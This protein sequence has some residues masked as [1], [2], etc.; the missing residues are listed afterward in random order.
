MC[1]LTSLNVLTIFSSDQCVVYKINRCNS[2]DEA[3]SIVAPEVAQLPKGKVHN[4]RRKSHVALVVSLYGS[5][6]AT[7]SPLPAPGLQ[8]LIMGFRCF[9][10]AGPLLH[11]AGFAMSLRLASWLRVSAHYANTSARVHV[12]RTT[13]VRVPCS[14]MHT[15]Q[16]THVCMYACMGQTQD[17]WCEVRGTARVDA[18]E[19]FDVSGAT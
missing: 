2:H 15:M 14:I 17:R 3:L 10:E 7:H 19:G 9:R 1:S 6:H 11:C 18:R 16:D 8:V 12:H 5:D 13:T 4:R